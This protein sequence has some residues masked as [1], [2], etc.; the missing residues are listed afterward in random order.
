MVKI[1][2]F[3][4]SRS[5]PGK[6]EKLMNQKI[7][8]ELGVYPWRECDPVCSGETGFRKEWSSLIGIGRKAG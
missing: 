8:K 4:T 6:I 7:E 3:C 2:C 5:D 1:T